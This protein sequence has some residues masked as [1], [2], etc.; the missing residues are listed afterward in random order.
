MSRDWL[1]RPYPSVGRA[2]RACAHGLVRARARRSASCVPHSRGRDLHLTSIR[3]EQAYYCCVAQLMEFVHV[4]LPR[5]M[6]HIYM[7]GDSHSLSSA[8]HTVTV[9]GQRRLLV[10]KLV[11][12]DCGGGVSGVGGGD[13]DDDDDSDDDDSDLD[14]VLS[15]FN[16]VPSNLYYTLMALETTHI[17]ESELVMLGLR[18]NR[19][20]ATKRRINY[21]TERYNRIERFRNIKLSVA[22]E[23]S[24][25]H[26]SGSGIH[27]IRDSKLLIK[28]SVRKI[29][30]HS[31]L[32]V[33]GTFPGAHVPK[34]FAMHKLLGFC[35]FDPQSKANIISQ[36][37]AWASGWLYHTDNIR[38]QVFMSHPSHPNN[39][40]KFEIGR[41]NVLTGIDAVSFDTWDPTYSAK[42]TS[43]LSTFIGES[44]CRQ[45]PQSLSPEDLVFSEQEML[46]FASPTMTDHHGRLCSCALHN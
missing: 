31:R 4:P 2:H 7:C 39:T 36:S 9:K 19:V 43:V 44:T 17:S 21:S 1:Y 42:P 18:D 25:V 26:D 24:V 12:G 14:E 34:Y 28:D 30:K 23:G 8:W 6:P 22:L 37:Q 45:L 20:K 15:N 41:E 32:K 5:E 33:Q 35:I 11:T 16:L 10:P 46:A 29:S 38:R 27:I 40:Y 13:D 3:N